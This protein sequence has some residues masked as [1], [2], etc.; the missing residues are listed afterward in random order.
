MT[1]AEYLSDPNSTLSRAKSD[2]PIFVI[3]ATDAASWATVIDWVNRASRLGA[4]V[5]KLASAVGVAAD[6]L[7]YAGKHGSKVP[8]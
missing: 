6:M 4:A 8:D 7:A 2:E 3:R 5:P 1:K